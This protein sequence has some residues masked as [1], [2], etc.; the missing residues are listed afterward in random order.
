MPIPDSDIMGEGLDEEGHRFDL[1]FKFVDTSEQLTEWYGQIIYEGQKE[2]V[3]FNVDGSI[4]DFGF[5]KGSGA[6]NY[7]QYT[8][9]GQVDKDKNTFA[10]VAK[11]EQFQIS[12]KG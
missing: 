11:Y 3:R 1:K 9:E 10:C 2:N 7:G 5:I 6:D 4:L 12:F 8:L